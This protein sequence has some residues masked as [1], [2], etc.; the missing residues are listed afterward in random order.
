MPNEEVRNLPAVRVAPIEACRIVES[1]MIVRARAVDIHTKLKTGV[2]LLPIPLFT[3]FEE[4]FGYRSVGQLRLPDGVLS[5]LI[6][7]ARVSIR[8]GR[9]GS[10]CHLVKSNVVAWNFLL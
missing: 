10:G 2:D 6:Q 5:W 4:D 9:S 7:N 3:R 1:G 8:L